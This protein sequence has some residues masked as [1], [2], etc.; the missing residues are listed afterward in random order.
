MID[1]TPGD[2]AAAEGLWAR[3]AY[4]FDQADNPA[5]SLEQ[6]QRHAAEALRLHDLATATGRAHSEGDRQ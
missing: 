6:R 5:L 4:H 3:Y 2:G 1:A